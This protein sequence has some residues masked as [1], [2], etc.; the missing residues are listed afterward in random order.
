MAKITKFNRVISY[1]LNISEDERLQILAALRFRR[2]SLSL[3]SKCDALTEDLV[4]VLV[5]AT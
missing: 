5:E 1:D 2:T 3:S 4:H